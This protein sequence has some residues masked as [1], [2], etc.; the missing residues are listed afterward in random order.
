MKLKEGKQILR[1]VSE[2]L[3]ISFESV[4]DPKAKVEAVETDSGKL[5]LVNCKPLF[6]KVKETFLPTLLFK[7]IS[8][9]VPK[10]VIDMGAVPYVC[11]G[12]DIMA[13][14]VVRL[15]GGFSEGDLVLIVDEKHRKPLALG[16]ILYN[17]E[18]AK[19]V[20]HGV[21][22]KN[23]HFVGDKIWNLAKAVTG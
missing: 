16:E 9:F 23:L 14:G 15:E 22:V 1:Q 12:A 20:K 18:E 8:E 7:E 3:K 11:N 19:N 13:P 2:R 10:V 17:A 4:L 5:I 21:V 6:F